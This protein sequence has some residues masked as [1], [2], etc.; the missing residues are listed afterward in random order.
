MAAKK[1]TTS[2]RR[3]AAAVSARGDASP[4]TQYL[5]VLFT[6]LSIVYVAIAYWRYA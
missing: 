3:A 5:V 4:T 6:F 1:K 2:K